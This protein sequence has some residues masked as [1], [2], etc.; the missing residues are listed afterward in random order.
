MVYRQDKTST[1]IVPTAAMRQGDFSELL[2]P[3]NTFFRRTRVVTDPNTGAPFA[4]NVIPSNRLSP[5]G[6]GILNSY[7]LPIP[8]FLQGT[9]NWIETLAHPIDSR[10]DSIRIDYY[11]SD[12]NRIN[13]SGTHFSYHED[14]PFALPDRSTAPTAAGT[15]PT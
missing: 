6:I 9:S 14:D 8:G 2:S 5:N 15:A 1:G 12:K 3:A 10:R 4:N 7:P 13:F 11:V